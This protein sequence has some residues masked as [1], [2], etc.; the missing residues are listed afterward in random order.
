[1]VNIIYEFLSFHSIRCP[2]WCDRILMN[3]LAMGIIHQVYIYYYLLC[4]EDYESLSFVV[5]VDI[6]F[7]HYLAMNITY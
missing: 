3:D 6:I 2:A 4:Y 1:M 5:T 7:C